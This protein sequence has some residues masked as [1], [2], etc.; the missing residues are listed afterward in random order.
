MIIISFKK[1]FIAFLFITVN[2]LS[3]SIGSWAEID[4]LIHTRV[5]YSSIKLD[6]GKIL[7]IGGSSSDFY[8]DTNIVGC[9]IFDPNNET[10]TEVAPMLNRRTAHFSVKL[11]NG[12]ILVCGGKYPIGSS[13][14]MYKK[15][16]IY[17]PKKNEWMETDSMK[18]QR[19]EAEIVK[20]N[21]GRIL[22][23]GGRT[24]FGEGPAAEEGATETCEIYN[25]E[26][27]KWKL[28]NS[29]SMKRTGHSAVLLS[30]GK[31]LVSG[32]NWWGGPEEASCEIF[33]L[34]TETWG[35]VTPMNIG[36]NYHNSILLDNNK[37]MVIGGN[38]KTCEVYDYLTDLWSYVAPQK[39]LSH[40]TVKMLD[41]RV[42]TIT[43]GDSLAQ[44]Y[45]YSKDEWTVSNPL[46]T[47]ILVGKLEP[48]NDGRV[49]LIGGYS[50]EDNYNSVYIYFP[51]S[52]VSKVEEKKAS[53]ISFNLYQNYP[54]PFNPSTT[55][56]Y[57]IPKNEKRK[58][59]NVRLT[60]YDILGRE[61]TTLVN[62]AKQ[63]GNYEVN[64]DASSLT[65]GMYFY[66]LRSGNY[67]AVKKMLLLR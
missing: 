53:D 9:E 67:R 4:G 47:K 5:K 56:K 14:Y 28:T 63:P 6:N 24:M 29:L 8:A 21:D 50:S 13:K 54:N 35:I 3:Q 41:G 20:L 30:N 66:E 44:I 58:T 46:P 42:L 33:D 62:E 31:V 59:I 11:S 43:S 39:I 19:I 27:G 60:V 15:C 48:L 17:F 10:W 52:T 45:N 23:I 26:T 7:V 34:S 55:I 18:I 57:Q 16:E 22:V 51:D 64:F 61:V 65:S 40:E 37:V 38:N 49:L 25:P 36:R 32:G 12:N 1:H 2:V